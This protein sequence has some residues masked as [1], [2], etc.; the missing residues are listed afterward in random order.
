MSTSNSFRSVAV[1]GWVLILALGPAC[2]DGAGTTT[3]EL[4][5]G[6][7]S[8]GLPGL[9]GTAGAGFG[10]AGTGDTAGGAAA[11]TQGDGSNEA[12]ALGGG[13]GMVGAAGSGEFG[14]EAGTGAAGSGSAGNGA[15]GTGA[16]G[17]G[18]D[19]YRPPCKTKASQV[20]I[21]GDSYINWGTHTFGAD[22]AK[23]AGESWRMY[24]VGGHSLGS[25]GIGS[26]PAQLD[27]ALVEDKNIIA[28][29][30]DGGG[31]DV[32]IPAATWPGGADCKNRADAA[33]LQVC[34]DIIDTA[35]EAGRKMMVKAGDNGIRDVVYF[36]YP[37]VPEGTLIGGAHPNAILDYALPKAKALCDG[38]EAETGGKMRC[39]FVDTI[40]IFAAQ[41]PA[42]VFASGDIHENSKGSALIAKAVYQTMKDNCIA[43]P[44][45][46]GCCEP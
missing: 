18:G 9:D 21:V 2:S 39:H 33:S 36:F 14:D 8:F 30:M 5:G 16:A 29:V 23:E 11:S 34:K 7:G 44:A 35:I 15:A 27:Q 41:K 3:D 40:P 32:L 12:G 31:N 20:I 26:I 42:D 25:G 13:A 24:A 4:L 46:S 10:M 37:H 43:Q 19:A 38:A 45:S 6:A 22:L 1:L 28:S 17:S